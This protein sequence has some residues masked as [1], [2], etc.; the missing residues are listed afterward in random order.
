MRGISICLVWHVMRYLSCLCRFHFVG[1]TFGLQ[2]FIR[3][4]KHFVLQY[5]CNFNSPK[6]PLAPGCR[7]R[8]SLHA[9]AAVYCISDGRLLTYHFF[10]YH[11]VPPPVEILMC[12]WRAHHSTQLTEILTRSVI[13][14]S[15]KILL[16]IRSYI[17]SLSSLNSL[18]FNLA[19]SQ[20]LSFRFRYCLA[21]VWK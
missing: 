6:N 16:Q 20:A 21:R 9:E 3:N 11:Q 4:L 2:E 18:V 1:A 8:L 17:F 15:K 19:C 12:Y 13:V 10:L 14:Y 7:T 5:F